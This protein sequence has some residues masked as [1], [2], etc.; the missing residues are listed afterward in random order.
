MSSILDDVRHI[1]CCLNDKE[2][3]SI[4]LAGCEYLLDPARRIRPAADRTPRFRWSAV[5]RIEDLRRPALIPGGREGGVVAGASPPMSRAD[6]RGG[7]DAA[8]CDEAL[9]WRAPA[10]RCAR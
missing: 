4:W 6:A 10:G 8:S 9:G 1:R 7:D 2:P 3:Y 5:R